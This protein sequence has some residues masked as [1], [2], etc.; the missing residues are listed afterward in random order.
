MSIKG[1]IF[2]ADGV[3][4][5]SMGIWDQAPEMYLRSKG[6]TPE[7]H[8]GQKMF[9]MSMTEGAE[10]IKKHYLVDFPVTK[11]LDGVTDTICTFYEQEVLL[12]PG[13]EETL[14][15]IQKQRIP[16]TVATSSEKNVISKA[17]ERL[18]I[19]SCFQQV[20]SCEEVGAGK[21]RPDIYYAAQQEMACRVEETI[22]FEDSFYALQTAKKAGFVTVGVYDRFSE[23]QR[24]EIQML[25]DHYLGKL[26]ADQVR[27][28]IAQ[29]DSGKE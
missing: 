4:L 19:F 26:S 12:K 29:H 11:I 13:V 16:M 8:L 17:F 2:D 15:W 7:K 1:I 22:V 6:I 21:D 10:Y 28:C 18:G 14:R 25:A 23:N 3:L 24:E 9:A 5:D 27:A 20:F